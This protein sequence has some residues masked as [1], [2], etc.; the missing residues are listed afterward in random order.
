MLQIQ[1]NQYAYDYDVA[2]ILIA[3]RAKKLVKHLLH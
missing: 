2:T 3:R 1:A